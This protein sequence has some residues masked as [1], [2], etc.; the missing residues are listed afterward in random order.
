[1]KTQTAKINYLKIAPRKVR[2]IADTLKGLSIQE[3]E[4][5]LLL[6]VQRSAKPLLKLIR[7]AVA[8]PAAGALAAASLLLLA[9]SRVPEPALLLGCGLAGILL[10]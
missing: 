10:R 6:R 1:M 8:D 9:R 3:A 2:L 5:Q 7:S 4:A